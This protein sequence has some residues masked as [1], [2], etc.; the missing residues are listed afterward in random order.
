MGGI[1]TA[2]AKLI[3]FGEHA[4]VYGHP[5]VG[6]SLPESTTV[7]LAGK[8]TDSWD[9]RS[10][11]SDDQSTVRGILERIEDL[12][13][14]RA[15]G[16][17][18]SV[19]I[20][21]SVPRGVG[22]GSSAALCGA[23]ARAMIAH[24]GA[25]A[26][27]DATNL[28]W[29]LAHAAEKLFHGTPSGVDTGLSLLG[30]MCALSPQP[31][32]LPAVER[33]PP[34]PLWLVVAGVPRDGSCGALIG[35]LSDHM[36]SGDPAARAAVDALGSLSRSACAALRQPD[37]SR[38]PWLIGEMAT[39]AMG[40]LRS[41]GLAHRD[42]DRLIDAGMRSGAL[43]GKLSGAGA[44]GAFFLVARGEESAKLI[45]RQVNRDAR[46]ARIALSATARVV[47]AGTQEGPA[48]SR[49]GRE[50]GGRP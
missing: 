12:L 46:V 18:C 4:A 41:I 34:S 21:S 14:A 37:G 35:R 2:S 25:A 48:T 33:L 24:G 11:V 31:S 19:S 29:E 1:G 9:M 42:Q 49:L 17:R 20:I 3:L 22:F 23:C 47:C 16:A 5:A 6:M 7:R 40:R 27:D 45:A 44:G 13:P 28:A 15:P 43:G 50:A 10:V 26:R 38:L 30:G 8:T 32:G 39:E 36:R